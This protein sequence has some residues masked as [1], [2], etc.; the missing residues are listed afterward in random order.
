MYRPTYSFFILCTKFHVVVCFLLCN[1][2]ASEFYMPTFRNTLFYF[3]SQEG[4][5]L[6]MKMEHTECSEKLAYK[7]R[8]PGNDTAESIQHSQHGESLKSREKIYLPTP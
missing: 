2:P 6:P 8:T 4:T 7:I 1:Y 3:H 5:Y